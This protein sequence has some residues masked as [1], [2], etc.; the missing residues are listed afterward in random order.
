MS[1]RA[2]VENEAVRLL[3]GWKVC[4]Y[5]CL[6]LVLAT[7]LLILIA[8]ADAKRET[9]MQNMS[10]IGPFVDLQLIFC[11]AIFASDTF[12]SETHRG[13][14]Q[15]YLL[16]PQ[17]RSK[18]LGS[19]LVLPVV[20]F[21]MGLTIFTILFAFIPNS[22]G[23]WKLWAAMIG[24]D[25]LIFFALLFMTVF[26]SIMLKGGGATALVTS[27]LM[28]FLFV[29]PFQTDSTYG[30]VNPFYVG[31]SVMKDLWDGALDSWWPIITLGLVLALFAALSHVAIT[32]KE[33]SE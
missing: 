18:I 25:S 6:T 29:W 3:R 32:R 7:F 1:A 21:Y 27:I 9:P 15:L 5:L 17:K 4:A 31:A 12:S 26:I 13:T 20:F 30:G 10:L 2:L 23:F 28:L 22:T 11:L 24:V 14:L 33:A 16:L 8:T 19:K